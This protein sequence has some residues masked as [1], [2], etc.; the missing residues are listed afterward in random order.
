MYYSMMVYLTGWLFFTVSLDS[1]DPMCIRICD[2]FVKLSGLYL[3]F[4]VGVSDRSLASLGVSFLARENLGV[5]S[6][7]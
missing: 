2:D 3:D 5:I 7:S 6:Y 4:V 1:T